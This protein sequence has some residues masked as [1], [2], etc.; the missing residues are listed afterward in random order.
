MTDVLSVL[1]TVTH[2]LAQNAPIKAVDAIV[3]ANQKH[4]VNEFALHAR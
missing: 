3:V 4:A 2:A 1:R